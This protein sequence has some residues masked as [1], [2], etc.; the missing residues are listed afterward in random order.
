MW[1]GKYQKKNKILQ[2]GV[3]SSNK[4]SEILKNGIDIAMNKFN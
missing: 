1:Y 2:Q 4:A 3:K